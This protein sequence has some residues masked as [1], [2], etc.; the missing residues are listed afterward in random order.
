LGRVFTPQTHM[1]ATGVKQA[2]RCL[3]EN[4][5]PRLPHWS[6]REPSLVSFPNPIS[7]TYRCGPCGVVGD[8]PASSKRSGKSIGFLM[9]AYIL[10]YRIRGPSPSIDCGFDARRT[11]HPVAVPRRL[12]PQSLILEVIGLGRAGPH[13]MA[14][15][16]SHCLRRSARPDPTGLIRPRGTRDNDSGLRECLQPAFMTAPAGISP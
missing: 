7:T 6:P 2:L 9:A 12:A 10:L 14:A 16:H 3:P 11:S 15:Y 13:C 1:R 4:L 8:A 5:L